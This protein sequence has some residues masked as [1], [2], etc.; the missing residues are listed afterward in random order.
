MKI[1]KLRMRQH[2]EDGRPGIDTLPNAGLVG[3]VTDVME[4]DD[5]FPVCEVTFPND[6]GWYEDHEI[7]FV[8]TATDN[9]ESMW[10]MWGDR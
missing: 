9:E 6:R 1:S 5:G 8:G 3:I 10:R 7:E 4:M 2:P